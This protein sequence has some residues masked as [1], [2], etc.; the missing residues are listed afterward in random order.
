MEFQTA[1]AKFSFSIAQREY[2]PV[3]AGE[4]MMFSRQNVTWVTSSRSRFADIAPE[5]PSRVV[6]YPSIR[7]E[8]R[9][10]YRSRE[11]PDRPF[12]HACV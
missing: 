3:H 5:L 12:R 2:R 11:R 1:A 9:A 6:G 10:P 8:C 7:T 4:F